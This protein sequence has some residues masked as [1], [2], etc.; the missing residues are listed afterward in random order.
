MDVQTYQWNAI[1]YAH[2]STI[3]QQWARELIGKLKLARL[4][5]LI[6][7]IKR[8]HWEKLLELILKFGMG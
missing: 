3:Q 8:E 4:L 5:L 2:S 1:D 6:L 7:N